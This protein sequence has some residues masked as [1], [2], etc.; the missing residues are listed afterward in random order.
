MDGEE[1]YWQER[2][3]PAP[4]KSPWVAGCDV[5][6]GSVTGREYRLDGDPTHT[7]VR[8]VGERTTIGP[9]EGM[10]NVEGNGPSLEID[11]ADLVDLVRIGDAWCGHRRRWAA[12]TRGWFGKFQMLPRSYRPGRW[13]PVRPYR[14]DEV[15]EGEAGYHPT[16]PP[17]GEMFCSQ[18]VVHAIENDLGERAGIVVRGP[19]DL[20]V[21]LVRG[22]FVV[23]SRWPR[24]P[25]NLREVASLLIRQY[26]DDS[27]NP[28]DPGPLGHFGSDVA[29]V[30]A[31]G[32]HVLRQAADH[33][34]DPGGPSSAA[35]GSGYPRNPIPP[36]PPSPSRFIR[37]SSSGNVT[38]RAAVAGSAPSA[39]CRWTAS[40]AWAMFTALATEVGLPAP[41]PI[42]TLRAELGR[43]ATLTPGDFAVIRRQMDL[44]GRPADAAQLVERLA[45]ECRSKRDSDTRTAA[46]GFRG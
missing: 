20:C 22:S 45:A 42:S 25:S 11:R 27:W 24:R 9:N 6:R 14:V 21:T 28:G 23:G 10:L 39:I 19:S 38:M 31:L 33:H 40:Q 18:P 8:V 2:F 46:I 32:L 43:L 35:W 4:R 44:L 5:R 12:F 34:E 7:I 37:H 13:T 29:E 16:A 30:D 41:E 26:T 1:F 36:A 3:G 15:R 17:P